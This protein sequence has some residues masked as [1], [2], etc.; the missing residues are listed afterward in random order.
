M[1][2]SSIHEELLWC[3]SYI[4]LNVVLYSCLKRR[5][6]IK[7]IVYLTCTVMVALCIEG[8][9]ERD[10]AFRAIKWHKMYEKKTSDV[11]CNIVKAIKKRY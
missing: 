8:F 3:Q 9:L 6:L 5:F 4:L 1:G 10:T 7:I 2:S 11:K